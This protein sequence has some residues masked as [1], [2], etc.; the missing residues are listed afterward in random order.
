VGR[1][2]DHLDQRVGARGTCCAFAPVC[3]LLRFT[4]SNVGHGACAEHAIGERVDGAEGQ[5]VIDVVVKIDRPERQD[6]DDV[7][8]LRIET[9]A[10]DGRPG[11]SVPLR[12]LAAVTR[13]SG[14]NTVVREGVQRKMVVQAN[15][16]GRDLAAVVD[17]I[18]RGV[19][20][21][22][23]LPEGVFVVYGGQFES[24][25]QATR[26][27]GVLSL[28]SLTGMFLALYTLFRSTNLAL[29]VLAALPMAA[30]GSVA[31]YWTLLRITVIVGQAS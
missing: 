21:D 20:A 7:R 8:D 30:I 12:A 27:I 24:Q 3:R 29:Q 6:V 14:P 1:D 2:R 31:A 23:V 10:I 17:D 26:M 28:V 9:P 4:Q 5:R 22:V 25:R 19:A 16:A 11:A 13:T 18:Q 15:V